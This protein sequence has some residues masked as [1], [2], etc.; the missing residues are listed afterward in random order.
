[1][2]LPELFTNRPEPVAA[3]ALAALAAHFRIEGTFETLPSERD[4]NVLITTRNGERFL[5]KIKNPADPPEMARFE[6]EVLLRLEAAFPGL[7]VPRIIRAA[8]G[9]TILSTHTLEG[10][11]SVR[12]FSYIDGVPVAGVTASPPLRMS[13]GDTLGQLNRALASLDLRPPQRSIPW[14]FAQFVTL[15]PLADHCVDGELR[16]QALRLFER[17]EHSGFVHGSHPPIA[18]RL[19]QLLHN[20]FNPHN[21]LAKSPETNRVCA[22]IDFG[23]MASGPAIYDLAIASAYWLGEQEPLEAITQVCEG[24]HRHQPLTLEDIAA[25]PLLMEVRLLATV[26]ITR[27]RAQ[28]TPQNRAYILRNEPNA[29]AG[30]STLASLPDGAVGG[31]LQRRLRIGS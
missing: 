7:A 12:L 29:L 26:L 27:W 20:D 25:L 28:R 30:L 16:N 11:R 8:S 10:Y 2:P 15:K 1:M 21:L 6:T 17:W 24:Y 31:H 14:D 5:L 13:I 23:D 18:G 4:Q 9:D 22:V 19:P 3:P